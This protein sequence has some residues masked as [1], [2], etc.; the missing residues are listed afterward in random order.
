M[1]YG[2]TPSEVEKARISFFE[3]YGVSPRILIAP[4]CLQ[5]SDPNLNRFMNLRVE[6]SARIQYGTFE[7]Y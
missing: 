4:Y 2:F 3:T 1:Y 6:F 7:V 5:K